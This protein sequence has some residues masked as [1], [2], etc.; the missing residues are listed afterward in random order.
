MA[1]LDVAG[2]SIG[3]ERQG[4]GPPLVLLHGAM[5]DRRVWRAEAEDLA[6]D[7]E[8]VAWDAPGHGESSDPPEDFGLEDHARCLAGLL[9]ALGTGPAHVVGH[10]WGGG[11]A[12]Q[13]AAAHPDAV[14]SL[15]LVGAYAGWAGSLPPG[16]VAQRLAFALD[17]AERLAGGFDLWSTPGLWSEGVDPDRVA[18]LD[19]MAAGLRPV[20]MRVM[21][22][23][24][25]RAD[26]RDALPGIVVPTLLLYGDADERAPRAVAEGLHAALP[27]ST[28]AI[29][30]GLTHELVLEAPQL[31]TT[32]VRAFLGGQRVC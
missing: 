27:C 1:V 11:L 12:L 15:V 6:R 24:F 31:F 18:E 14:A 7:L 17:A 2:L 20:G 10:S 22:Q 4:S 21:A 9:S 8:V 3:Y 16:D 25:A 29:V 23:G 26:L 13:L 28:L 32:A 30:P 19:A 5:C